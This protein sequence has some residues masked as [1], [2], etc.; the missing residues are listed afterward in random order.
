[1]AF[2]CYFGNSVRYSQ[3][4]LAYRLSRPLAEIEAMKTTEFMEWLAFFEIQAELTRN[5]HHGRIR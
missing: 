4:A 2:P 1:M 5:K 3:L